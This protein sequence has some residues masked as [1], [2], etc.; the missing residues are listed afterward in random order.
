M[1]SLVRY[2]E[3]GWGTGVA[4]ERFDPPYSSM[5]VLFCGLSRPLGPGDR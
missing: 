3:L 5:E 4:R 2:P 1:H